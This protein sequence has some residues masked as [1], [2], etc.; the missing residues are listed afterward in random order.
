M[1]RY[2]CINVDVDVDLGDFDTE[3]L[4]EELQSRGKYQE[5]ESETGY[6]YIE[7]TLIDKIFQL[8]RQGKDYEKELDLYLYQVTG[9]AI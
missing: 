8:R 9:R 1:S 3:D 2:K 6:G 4:I 5:T 7:G